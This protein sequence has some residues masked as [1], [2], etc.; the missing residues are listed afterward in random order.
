MLVSMWQVRPLVVV[1]VIVVVP[2][3]VEMVQ[4]LA[5]VH[6]PT[7]YTALTGHAIGQL[8]LLQCF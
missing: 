1:V 4:G 3:T 8:L 6:L 5:L 2:V 7:A